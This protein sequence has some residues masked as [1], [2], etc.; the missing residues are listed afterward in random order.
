MPVL[1]RPHRVEPLMNAIE[2]TTH[3]VRVHFI[4]D[5]DDEDQIHAVRTDARGHLHTLAGNYAAKTTAAIAATD[6][7]LV[8]TGADDLQPYPGWFEKAKAH[9]RGNVQ[10]V[11]VND[12]VGRPHRPEHAAHF[13]MTREYAERPTIDGGPGP[14]HHGYCH[15]FCDDELIATAR[16]RGVYAYASDA[17]VEH[18]H[19]KAGKAPDDDTYRKGREN[20]E[21]DRSIFNGR[22][23]LWA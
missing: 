2:A 13:L 19:A 1:G 21:L 14:F 12:L 17:V 3:G 5:P 6:S 8:F 20:W 10:V 16:K 4:C 23:G 11:G 9:L 22:A 7:Q 15:W 18:L